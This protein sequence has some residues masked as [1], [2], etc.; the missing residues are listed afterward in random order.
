[1]HLFPPQDPPPSEDHHLQEQFKYGIEFEDEYDYLQHLKE[2]GTAV[3]QPVRMADRDQPTIG[4]EK[5]VNTV[6]ILNIN[7]SKL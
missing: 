2:P 7:V 4:G 6:F 3:L 5:K 1:M